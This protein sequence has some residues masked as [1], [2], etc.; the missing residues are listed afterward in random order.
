MY[1]YRKYCNTLQRTATH[2]N[3]MQHTVTHC[4]TLQHTAT[5][6]NSLQH[7][8][9][10]CISLLNA[11]TIWCDAVAYERQPVTFVPAI[12]LQHTATHC[13]T[14]QHAR[15][16]CNN[17]IWEGTLAQLRQSVSCYDVSLSDR[18]SLLPRFSEQSPMNYNILMSQHDY[19]I[20]HDVILCIWQSTSLSARR[21]LLPRF[22]E[23]RPMSYIFSLHYIMYMIVYI[24]ISLQVSFATFQ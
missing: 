23:K 5:H 21:S 24:I 17:L 16:R 4:N 12:P 9:T 22:S 11:L 13:N 20:Q 8:T 3:A 1:T 2:C 14:L 15:P 6:C 18:R 19:C 10:H 7:N